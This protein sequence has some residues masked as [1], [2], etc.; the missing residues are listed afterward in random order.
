MT[1]VGD[2][3]VLPVQRSSLEPL[4][5]SKA[6]IIYNMPKKRVIKV[7]IE[8]CIRWPLCTRQARPQTDDAFR[9]VVWVICVYRLALTR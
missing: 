8:G 5:F 2:L 4:I 7:L 1:G 6:L 3:G 9:Y